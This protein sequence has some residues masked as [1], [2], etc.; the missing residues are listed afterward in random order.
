MPQLSDDKPHY[1][2]AFCQFCGWASNGLTHDVAVNRKHEA[3]HP[4]I[5]QLGSVEDARQRYMLLKVL[6]EPKD[7]STEKE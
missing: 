5:G 3:S 1:T 2:V 7:C 4:E 6:L